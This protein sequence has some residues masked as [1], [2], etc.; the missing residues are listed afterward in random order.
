[1][2]LEIQEQIDRNNN[3]LKKEDNTI[4]ISTVSHKGPMGSSSISIDSSGEIISHHHKPTLLGK[5]F[6]KNP[7]KESLWDKIKK[8]IMGWFE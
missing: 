1:M 4:K 7:Y 3:E 6:E 8:R 5:M 2:W